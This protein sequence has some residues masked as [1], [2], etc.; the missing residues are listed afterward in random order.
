MASSQF[1]TEQYTSEQFVE[2]AGAILFHLST[3]KICV[4]HLH[5]HNEYVLAK[6]RRNCG[7][8]RQESALREV[9]EETGYQCSLLPVTMLS[10]A[11]PAIET[12]P[13]RDKPRL[14]KDCTEPFAVQIR[15]LNGNDDNV[16]IIWWYLA[17]VEEGKPVI[18]RSPEEEIFSVEFY[19]Y[20][21][22]IDKLTYELDRKIVKKA[23]E[24]VKSSYS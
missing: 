1:K 8:H 18:Q 19:G 10:R 22:V 14:Y 2:S 21:Q 6:G 12:A 4:L 11:P 5:K 13:S 15:H 3:Q 17:K 20:D 7:E 23:I 16:K 24:C 9:L